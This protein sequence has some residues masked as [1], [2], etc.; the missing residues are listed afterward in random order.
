MLHIEFM[1]FCQNHWSLMCSIHIGRNARFNRSIMLEVLIS[2]Y[3]CGP[4]TCIVISMHSNFNPECN[5]E[6][7]QVE[8]YRNQI[9]RCLNLS[10]VLCQPFVIIRL[11]AKC[12]VSCI[13]I[14]VSGTLIFARNQEFE[15]QQIGRFTKISRKSGP[16][17]H[18]VH[19]HQIARFYKHFTDFC[20]KRLKANRNG[21]WTGK[22]FEI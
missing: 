17:V 3:E 18:L 5:A 6:V 11:P 16:M 15:I 7:Y 20:L 2:D 8:G 19:Q 21:I 22:K 10:S 9:K 12:R 13:C 1:K 14:W 4:E